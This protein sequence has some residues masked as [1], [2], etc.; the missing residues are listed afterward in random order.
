[1]GRMNAIKPFKCPEQCIVCTLKKKK[2]RQFNQ[3]KDSSL[4][5]SKNSMSVSS[6]LIL[7]PRPMVGEGGR[8]H[9]RS[10]GGVQRRFPELVLQHT[11]LIAVRAHVGR[12]YSAALSITRPCISSLDI[13]FYIFQQLKGKLS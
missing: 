4:A 12:G 13:I 10:M 9:L 5:Q 1:M 7:P 11:A 2:K 6:F 8:V 3:N